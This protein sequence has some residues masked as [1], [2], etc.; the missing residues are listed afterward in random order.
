MSSIPQTQPPRRPRFGVSSSTR[1]AAATLAAAGILWAVLSRFWREII[2]A[3]ESA[4]PH[5]PDLALFARLPVSVQVHILAALGALGLGAVLMLVRKG[6]AFHRV[7]GWTWVSLVALVAGSSLTMMGAVSHGK[8]S[9][10]HIFT[11]WTL[12]T[13]P[14]GV[15]WAKRHE[16][17]RHRGVMTGLFYGGFAINIFIAF[18]PGRT[19]WNLVFG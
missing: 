4:H 12:I 10:L 2:R 17:A 7:A 15:A 16:V 13:L 18:I 14:L 5:A 6:R 3:A 19:M 1:F 11:G 8:L 9:I